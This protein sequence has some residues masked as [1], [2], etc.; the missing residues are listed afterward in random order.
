MQEQ[1]PGDARERPAAADCGLLRRAFLL[2]LGTGPSLPWLGRSP[3]R[4]STGPSPSA[5]SPT[6]PLS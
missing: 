4:A 5:A 1:L 6:G 3:R 2:R